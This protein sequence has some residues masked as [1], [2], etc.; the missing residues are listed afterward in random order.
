MNDDIFDNHA[1]LLTAARDR[2]RELLA[3]EILPPALDQFT[4]YT[5][6]LDKALDLA[7]LIATEERDL[8]TISSHHEREMTKIMA[9]FTEVEHAMLIDQAQHD[10]FRD[11]QFALIN[12]LIDAEKFELA[13]EIHRRLMDGRPRSTVEQLIEL[14]NSSAPA[15]VVR[16]K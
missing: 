10:A 1:S 11:Q 3:G 7:K 4:V 12:R 14:R 5:G 9:A 2:G 16:P 6:L 8:Q 15:Y 13:S